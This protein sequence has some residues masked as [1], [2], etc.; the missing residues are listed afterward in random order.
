MSFSIIRQ[1]TLLR[2]GGGG[3]EWAN[4]CIIHAT[5]NMVIGV[6]FIKSDEMAGGIVLN[7]AD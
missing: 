3:E 5:T 4:Q 6:A 2:G 1:G 7:S